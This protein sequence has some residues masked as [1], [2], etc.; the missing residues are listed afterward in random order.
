[1]DQLKIAT[2][3]P[4]S[5]SADTIE[6]VVALLNRVYGTAEAGMWKDGWVRTDSQEIAKLIAKEE[7]IAAHQGSTLVGVVRLRQV[8]DDILEFGMLAVAPEQR[9]TG[10]GRALLKYVE[11]AAKEKGVPKMQ[12]EILVPKT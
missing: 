2:I 9:S 4:F 7:I 6:H 8:A 11:S 5:V 10:A 12:L 3:D 1:M